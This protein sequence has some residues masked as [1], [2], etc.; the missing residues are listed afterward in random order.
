MHRRI[1]SAIAFF[2]AFAFMAVGYAAISDELSISGTA[3]LEGRP[4]PGIYIRNVAVETDAGG[5]NVSVSYTS[6]TSV[7]AT[8]NARGSGSITYKITVENTSDG[9]YWYRGITVIGDLDGYNNS[10]IGAQRGITIAT[11]DKSGDSGATFDTSDWVPPQTTRDFYVTYSFGSSATGSIKTFVTFDFGAKIESYSDEVLAILNDP[12]KYAVLSGAFN[13]TYAE[14][15]STVLSNVGADADLFTS[16]FGTNLTLDGQP[17]TI[18]IERKNVDGKTT[19]DSYSSGGPSGCEYTI[20]VTT[21]DGKVYAVS[22]TT[23]SDGSWRQIG[24]LY[25]GTAGTSNYTDSDGNVSGQTINVSS[26]IASEKRYTMFSYNGFTVE[27]TVGAVYQGDQY[28]KYKT[29]GE[30]MGEKENQNTINW[31]I[32][33]RLNGG[34]IRSLLVRVESILNSNAGSDAPEI[35]MLRE[36]FDGLVPQYFYE[37]NPNEYL[38]RQSGWTR[39]DIIAALEKFQYALE[40]YDQVHG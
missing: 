13:D 9:T 25:E 10:L 4:S 20:Y 27:Y 33:N 39:A 37:N 15:G 5:I 2:M 17:V 18:A 11:K 7:E 6:P 34:Q 35:V 28:D 14:S 19:G 23:Q 31:E 29:I 40:Y 3:S 22:Y 21:G 1:I 30:L 12:E 26:W 16:L 24:E 38:M 32:F 36:A 8:V